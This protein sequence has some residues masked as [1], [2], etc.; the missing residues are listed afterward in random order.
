MS[1]SLIETDN[2]SIELNYPHQDNSRACGCHPWNYGQYF[3]I[4]PLDL[5]QQNLKKTAQWRY[6]KCQ[7]GWF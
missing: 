2:P 7:G 5:Y 6:F 3:N 4:S 1:G